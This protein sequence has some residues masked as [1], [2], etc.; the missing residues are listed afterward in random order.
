MLFCKIWGV[1]Q[2]EEH[3]RFLSY[4]SAPS[5][6][7]VKIQGGVCSRLPLIYE[8]V[9][10]VPPFLL[11]AFIYKQ[12]Y[13]FYEKIAF[14][15]RKQ[16]QEYSKINKESMN[17]SEVRMWMILKNSDYN[18]RRQ[19]TIG[20]FIVDFASLSHK[21]VIEIDGISHEG[22]AL[23]DTQRDDFILSNGYK[24]LRLVGMIPYPDSDIY[25]FVWAKVHEL[26]KG[27]TP[28]IVIEV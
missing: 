11:V 3:P 20:N 16:T 23:Y 28:R 17:L 27:N 19:Q 2:L 1:L 5:D 10:G 15:A 24:I 9:G 13:F 25:E 8:G 21:M 7:L 26:E 12:L 14:S 18:F 6:F 22:K 4:C